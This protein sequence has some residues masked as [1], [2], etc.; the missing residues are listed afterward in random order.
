MTPPTKPTKKPAKK[1]KQVKPLAVAPGSNWQKLKASV[2]KPASNKPK[3]HDLAPAPKAKKAKAAPSID[4]IDTSLIVAMDCEMVG[5]GSDGKRS[6]LARCSIVDFDGNV[7]YDEHVKPLERVTD[8]RTHVSGI[9][10]KSLRDA[11]PFE[12]CQKDVAAIFDGK[13]VVG[14]AIRNDM[15]ALML[16]HPKGMIR[17]TT[18]YRP[19]MRRKVNGTKLY[20]KALKH[21]AE[22]V[23]H[24]TIQTG[25]HDS[26]EDARITLELYKRA[27]GPWEKAIRA[28]KAP[29]LLVGQQPP[30]LHPKTKAVISDT[31]ATVD[32]DEDE[33]DAA[34]R[35][36]EQGRVKA[37]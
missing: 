18:K 31:P 13:I 22:E 19:Y 15:Q 28:S 21:L 32:S 26:V 20:P 2:A 3:K 36:M 34:I 23:L 7:V 8:F 12:Q 24:K 30:K 17:D 5:V 10:A 9:R 35:N 33:F 4:W 1:A 29:G 6:V 14:H 27:M 16:T 25:E 11:L 37:T